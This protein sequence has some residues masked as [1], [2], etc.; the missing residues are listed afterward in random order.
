MKPPYML[1]SYTLRGKR[2][3]RHGNNLALL[4]LIFFIFWFRGVGCDWTHLVRRPLIGLSYRPRMV[5]E[6]GVFGGIRT[7]G[8]NRSTLRKPIPVSRCPPQILH[9]LI[10]DRTRAA[11][12][13]CQ[14]L[15]AWAM[16]RLHLVLLK[17]ARVLVA[18]EQCWSYLK[19]RT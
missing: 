16:A 9:D 5:D 18:G 3:T 7:G 19:L 4:R 2:H 1:S 11:A 10:L 13:G 14:G 17:F 8:G 15:T 12:V 6:Y